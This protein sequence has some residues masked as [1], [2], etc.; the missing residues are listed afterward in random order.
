MFHET[1]VRECP[2]LWP[3]RLEGGALIDVCTNQRPV[4]W[5][6]GVLNG[7]H[8]RE[9]T[10]LKAADAKHLAASDQPVKMAVMT[11]GEISADYGELL[12]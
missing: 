7:F 5:L 4:D 10:K 3:Y 6:T 9:G 11:L 2:L 8:L 1:P 12:Q